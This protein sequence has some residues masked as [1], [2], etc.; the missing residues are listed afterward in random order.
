M[1]PFGSLTI[2]FAAHVRLLYQWL[3][4]QEKL[5]S[6]FSTMS[7]VS[8]KKLCKEMEFRHLEGARSRNFC[9]P[10]GFDM[11]HAGSHSLCEGGQVVVNQ[12]EKGNTCFVRAIDLV[13]VAHGCSRLMLGPDPCEWPG[14]HLR[15]QS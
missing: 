4:N 15:T 10:T 5:S 14:V 8:A 13:L 12:G 6:L 9:C 1:L 2:A 7:E 3:M 11:L